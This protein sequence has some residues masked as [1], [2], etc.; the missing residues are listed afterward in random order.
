M[1]YLFLTEESCSLEI[2]GEVIYDN[3]V[4]RLSFVRLSLMLNTIKTGGKARIPIQSFLRTGWYRRSL[5][6]R[7]Q[8]GRRL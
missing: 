2:L 3:L 5:T 6:S 1:V 7:H 8:A 4:M